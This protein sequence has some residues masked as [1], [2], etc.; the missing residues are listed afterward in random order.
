MINSPTIAQKFYQNIGKLFYAIAFADGKVHDKEFDSLKKLV[1]EDW[2]NNDHNTDMFG[3]DAVFQVEIVFDWLRNEYSS[4]KG[5]IDQF[6][7]YY[8][9]HTSMFSPEVRNRIW[10]SAL[11][12]AS[13]YAGR[14]KSELVM[15]NRLRAV[16]KPAVEQG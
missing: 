7:E 13:A 15:L 14:N 3:S 12:I 16:M 8:E 11:A 10:K 2:L 5:C 1:S 4:A 6:I 9:S